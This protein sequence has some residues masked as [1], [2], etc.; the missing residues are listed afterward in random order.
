MNEHQLAIELRSDEG[1]KLKSY[2][3]S[4]G[5]WTIGVGCLIDPKRG[6]NPAPFGIDLRNGG[7]ITANESEA[8]LL[9]HIAEKAGQLDIALP[10]WRT[11][12]DNRQRVLMNMVFQMGVAGVMAFKKFIAALK[13]GDYATAKLQMLDSTWAR[14][15]SPARARRLAERMVQG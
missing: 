3:D 10:W 11:L 2:L 8:L 5:Y 4:K 1:E 14:T 6:A 9:K 12:S 13:S 7:T 15:D